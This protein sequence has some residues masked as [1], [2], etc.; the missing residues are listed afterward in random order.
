MTPTI[1]I[2]QPTMTQ[3]EINWYQTKITDFK[4]TMK[5]E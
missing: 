1:K 3:A 2:K 5:G 4:Q